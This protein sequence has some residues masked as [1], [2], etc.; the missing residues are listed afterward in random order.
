MPKCGTELKPGWNLVSVCV[1]KSGFV[2]EVFN[3]QASQFRF[4]LRW[5][6]SKGGFD[7]YSPLAT[8][9]PFNTTEL[10]ESYFILVGNSISLG[11]S[12]ANNSDLSIEMLSGWNSPSWPYEFNASIT[13]YFN[14]SLH[15]YL[16]KWNRD[17]QS[18]EIYSALASNNPFDSINAGEGQ[19]I[20]AKT[21]HVLAYNRSQLL[22]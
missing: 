8:N 9:N 3:Y 17:S 7:V 19:F 22:N 16:M 10:N 18:F 15:K 20:F 12:G 5:N 2:D 4:L 6:T 14:I 11:W 13:K 1:N 21:Q